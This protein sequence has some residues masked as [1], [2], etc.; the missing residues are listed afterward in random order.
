MK[1]K[2]EISDSIYC[3]NNGLTRTLPKENQSDGV[4]SIS[5]K[6]SNY[7]A[8]L[9]GESVSNLIFDDEMAKHVG[10]GGLFIK[11]SR[12]EDAGTIKGV[13]T[14]LEFRGGPTIIK[15]PINLNQEE[16]I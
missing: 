4:D 11:N 9:V 10:P 12:K 7:V 1:G 8:Y 16:G 14:N 5:N 15:G 13:G 2:I 6:S 3:S